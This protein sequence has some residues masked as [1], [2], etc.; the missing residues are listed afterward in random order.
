MFI[1][2]YKGN[3]PNDLSFESSSP[4]NDY[5]ESDNESTDQYDKNKLLESSF[6]LDNNFDNLMANLNKDYFNQ[7]V[8][9]KP[10]LILEEEEEEDNY[11]PPYYINKK[12]FSNNHNTSKYSN[13]A[14][15]KIPIIKKENVEQNGVNKQICV[16][17]SNEITGVQNS[18]VNEINNPIHSSQKSTSYATESLKSFSKEEVYDII[19][20]KLKDVQIKDGEEVNKLTNLLNKK[21]NRNPE[22]SRNDDT[23][24][25]KKKLG[26]NIKNS[27][28]TGEHNK[29][30]EN[31]L[32]VKL[33]TYDIPLGMKFINSFLDKD[34]Q[35][36]NI[37][38]KI[39]AK[40][41]NVREN[42][43]FNK[44][45]HYEIFSSDISS[46]YKKVIKNNNGSRNYNQQ[47][48]QKYLVNDT[49]DLKSKS[50]K[51]Q[52]INMKRYEYRLIQL[53][54]ETDEIRNKYSKE[55]ID[56]VPKIE[57]IIKRIYEKEMKNKD[58]YTTVDQIQEHM[59]CL[60]IIAYNF[61][62][63]LSIKDPRSKRSGANYKKVVEE[64]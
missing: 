50:N 63:I 47:I 64:I 17:I 9:P 60:L 15:T 42:I 52:V 57:D 10:T 61:D 33:K 25:P 20:D 19:K 23:E 41:I 18:T 38:F 39:F 22:N 14:E 2:Y 1:D 45:S 49:K 21:R 30:K 29:N 54:L 26:R 35:L 53:H 31:N 59:Y 8:D 62:Y 56:S 36:L 51:V 37:D 4:F 16:E 44:L 32:M 11:I 34:E 7:I 55:V 40:N 58:H 46:A 13:L 27:G 24:K 5:I 3:S 6:P 12:Q 28:L 43:E 48:L